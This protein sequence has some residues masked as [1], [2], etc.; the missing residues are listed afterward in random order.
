MPQCLV[1]LSLH[2]SFEALKKHASSAVSLSE[3][4]YLT[5]LPTKLLMSCDAKG[6]ISTQ[7]LGAY[8][9]N[10]ILPQSGSLLTP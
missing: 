7:D 8:S 9:K 5:K 4:S 10:A 6:S 2:I 3:P 1:C